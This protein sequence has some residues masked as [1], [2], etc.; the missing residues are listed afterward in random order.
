MSP[1]KNPGTLERGAHSYHKIM[2]TQ[3][4]LHVSMEKPRNPRA[5]CAFR[6]RLMP[7]W[8]PPGPVRDRSGLFGD[9]LRSFGDRRMRTTLEGSWVF[10]WRHSKN[11]MFF[12]IL[13]YECAP[14]SRVPGFSHADMQKTL[15]FSMFYD[16]NAQ[17]SRGFLGLFIKH[18]ENTLCSLLFTFAGHARRHRA[19]GGA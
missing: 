1:W 8:G 9:P 17:H 15:C 19:A 4:F 13:W 11:I 10:P 14:R 12:T 18:H 6:G 2:K 5:W 3:G 16:T 7:V